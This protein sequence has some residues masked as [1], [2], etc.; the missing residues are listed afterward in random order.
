MILNLEERLNNG[1]GPSQRRDNGGHNGANIGGTYGRLTKIEFPKLDGWSSGTRIVPIQ[2][3]TATPNRTFKKLT[4]QELEEK[5]AKNLCFY[6]DQKYSPGHKCSGQMYSLEI[7]AYEEEGN[8]VNCEIFEGTL[9]ST[10]QWMQGKHVS[11]SLNQIGVEIYT[12]ALCV[13]PA[14]LMQM[15]GS[16]TKPNSNIQTLLQDF[17]IA[18]DTPKELPP[19][20]SHDHIIPLLP[21]TPPISVRPYKNP[22]NQKDAIELMVKELLEAGV[23]KNSQSSFSSPIVMVKKKDELLDELYGAKVF[24]KLDLR[25]GYHQIRMNPGDIH[26]IAFRTH[27]GHYEFLVIPFRLTNAPS[28]FQSLTNTVFKSYLRKFV[29]VFINDILVYSKNR[30]NK[31]AHFMAL[32][33]PYTASTV[34]QAFLDSVYKLHGLPDSIVSDRDRCIVVFNHPFLAVTGRLLPVLHCLG[35]LMETRIVGMHNPE[36]RLAVTR[37]RESRIVLVPVSDFDMVGLGEYSQ[38]VERFMNYLE[39]QTDGEAMINSIKNCDQPLP[40]VTQVSI[41][42]TSSTEQPPLKGKSMWSDQEKR[43]QKIDRLARSLLIQRLPNDIYSLIDSNKTAK[44]LRD[45]LARHMRGSEYGE[46][47]RKA[48]VL[49]KY[50]TFKATEGELLLDTYIRYLQVINDLKKCG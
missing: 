48:T 26:K 7:M 19:I 50:E 33:H 38:W 9:Q 16:S 36:T 46:Q 15:T 39:E 40:R 37:N 2:S 17:S 47:D 35:G 23:I 6:C 20:R 24:S 42:E 45:A 22:P 32:S 31:Y 14:T 21:N 25:S 8:N 18:F 29:L 11:N 5:R 44:Y 3:T 12:M 49:Y 1:E 43:I 28:T 4:R 41:A 30:L 34:A 13:C 27:K 10:L